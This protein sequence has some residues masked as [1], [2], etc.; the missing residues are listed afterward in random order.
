[1][2]QS[3]VSVIIPCYNAEKWVGEAIQSCLEQAYRPIEIIIIDDG[4]TD[5]SLT[6]IKHYGERYSDLI[7]YESQPNRGAPSAR[8]RGFELSRGDYI[9]WLDSDDR[10]ARGKLQCQVSI[11]QNDKADVVTGWWKN[12]IEEKPGLFVEGP[13]REPLLTDDPVASLIDDDGWAPLSSYL[14]TRQ[15]VDTVSGWNEKLTSVQDVDFILRIAMNG[16][17]FLVAQYLCGY[18]RRPLTATVST[19]DKTVF[20]QNC[21]DIYDRVYHFYQGGGWKEEYGRMLSRRY[22]WL[23]R[24]FFEHDRVMFER[25]MKQIQLFEPHY[26]PEGPSQLRWLTRILGYRNAE[27]IALWYR[28]T[29]GLVFK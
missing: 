12:L 14:M 26:V 4:S 1:M 11:L 21:F 2:S 10:M 6:I 16:A 18:Y 5:S 22:G 8:N 3:L 7:R 24:Y 28:M 19:R 13:V 20:M 27:Q 29:K 17:R 23:A 15:T 9:Q 25:C